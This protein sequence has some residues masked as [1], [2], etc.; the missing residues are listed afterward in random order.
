M[1]LPPSPPPPSL[2]RPPPPPPPPQPPQPPPS[3]LA[4]TSSSPYN[5]F[6]L[7]FDL[8]KHQNAMVTTKQDRIMVYYEAMTFSPGDTWRP[9]T[10]QIEFTSILYGTTPIDVW[11]AMPIVSWCDKTHIESKHWVHI[12]TSTGHLAGLVSCSMAFGAHLITS[13]WPRQSQNRKVM[14]ECSRSTLPLIVFR[15]WLCLSSYIIWLVY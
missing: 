15:L 7:P 5:A 8:E 12:F 10:R 13:L 14:S 1:Y 4:S 6:D 11:L 3:A 9:I 2:T